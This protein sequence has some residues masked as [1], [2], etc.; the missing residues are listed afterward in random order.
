MIQN[1]SPQNTTANNTVT[2]GGQCYFIAANTGGDITYIDIGGTSRVMT[3][4]T[5]VV[6]PCAAKQIKAT[7]TTAS[8]IVVWM[9]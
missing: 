5:G 2:L 9:P 4:P 7:G 6:W 3:I 8:G 1:L